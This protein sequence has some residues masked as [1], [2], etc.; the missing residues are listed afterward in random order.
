MSAARLAFLGAY[1]YQ[2][3]VP[4]RGDITP[5]KDIAYCARGL[6]VLS[7]G[8]NTILLLSKSYQL[9]KQ[10]APPFLVGIFISIRSSPSL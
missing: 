8:K 3:S 10:V 6:R 4:P 2:W 1:E 5:W 9:S 7:T